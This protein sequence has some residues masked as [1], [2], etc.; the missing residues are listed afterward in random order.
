MATHEKRD[1]WN[2]SFCINQQKKLV[3]SSYLHGNLQSA[4]RLL[5]TRVPSSFFDQLYGDKMVFDLWEYCVCFAP[6]TVWGRRRGGFRGKWGEQQSATLKKS[7][8]KSAGSR[9]VT[10]RGIPPPGRREGA[11]ERRGGWDSADEGI[12]RKFAGARTQGAASDNLL[13]HSS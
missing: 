4:L 1:Q 7:R 10:S 8:L 5:V 13:A 12:M 6:K 2:F 9:S 11:G 3:A